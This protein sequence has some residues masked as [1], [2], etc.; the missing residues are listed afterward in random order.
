[1]PEFMGQ[2]G[3]SMSPQPPP[4]SPTT[5]ANLYAT[6][7]PPQDEQKFQ[8][9]IVANKIPW[10]DSPDAD[11]DMR[12]YWKAQQ[13]GDPS[14]KQAANLHFP[15]TYKTPWHHSFSNES[16]YATPDAPKWYGNKLMGKDGKLVWDD[17][18]MGNPK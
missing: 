17:D 6:Q 13:S 4:P 8:Q 9:W 14:A 16:M 2:L 10:Q 12:G 15:D 7:L 11:Y 18:K 5:K 3:Q 1:M